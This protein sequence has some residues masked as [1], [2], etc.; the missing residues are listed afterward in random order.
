M[1]HMAE[2]NGVSGPYHEGKHTPF[3]GGSTPSF[4]QNY[5]IHMGKWTVL[6]IT[7]HSGKLNQSFIQLLFLIYFALTHCVKGEC[8]QDEHAHQYS[9]V[10][11]VSTPEH[12]AK[13]EKKTAE[14]EQGAAIKLYFCEILT[15][16]SP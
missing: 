2:E 1:A 12:A 16:T 8:H 6:E 9:Y 14:T 5:N 15:L 10:Y 7:Y 13:I 3:I 4:T 11:P